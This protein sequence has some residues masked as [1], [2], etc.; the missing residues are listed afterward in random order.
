MIPGPVRTLI[1]VVR[2]T[3]SWESV[4]ADPDLPSDVYGHDDESVALPRIPPGAADVPSSLAFSLYKSGST[5]LQL[6]LN[7]LAPKAGVSM[8]PLESMLW[9]RGVSPEQTPPEVARVFRPRSCCYGVF[10]SFPWRY[11]IPILADSPCILLVRDPRDALVSHY[12]SVANSHPEPKDAPEEIRR[13]MLAERDRV[14][15]SPIDEHVLA[16]AEFFNHWH[17]GY[18]RG[19]PPAPRTRVFRYEDVVFE[20]RAWVDEL[21]ETLGW[22]V[23]PKAR[24][25]IAD[26]FDLRPKKE[27]PDE[28]IRRV[29]P[30]D[31]RE[32]LRP[33]TIEA[34]N[35]RLA[36]VLDRYGY[37]R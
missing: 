34:L 8:V 9:D 28:H 14:G 16:N 37:E 21:C 29:T 35:Q 22:D 12:F 4:Q 7:A 31:H 32:K 2:R 13:G 36:P 20:K 15:A 30:G 10:R 25:R 17:E 3:P 5:L 23:P 27:R 26:A 18:A 24:R 6:I 33:D 1:R 19:L 11:E